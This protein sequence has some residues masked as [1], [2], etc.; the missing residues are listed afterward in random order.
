[1]A[2]ESANVIEKGLA[3]GE[4][5]TDLLINGVCKFKEV[6]VKKPTG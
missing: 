4:R 2:G 1:M 3:G 5:T 6:G